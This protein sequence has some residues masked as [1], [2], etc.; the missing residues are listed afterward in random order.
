MVGGARV[1]VVRVRVSGCRGLLTASCLACR[2]AGVGVK[3][4]R[5]RACQG[6]VFEVQGL[7]TALCLACHD[8]RVG[9]RASGM[10]GTSYKAGPSS[11]RRLP[12]CHSHSAVGLAQ[13]TRRPPSRTPPRVW[14]LDCQL[15]KPAG[16]FSRIFEEGR[17][18]RAVQT[19]SQ[20]KNKARATQ[21][22]HFTHTSASLKADCQASSGWYTSV[23]SRWDRSSLACGGR[24]RAT[25]LSHIGAGWCGVGFKHAGMQTNPECG[26]RVR[27]GA[28][29]H[30]QSHQ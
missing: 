15:S 4:I 21:R 6:R 23:C 25:F 13:T 7:L 16:P 1:R 8:G 24:A 3:V 19:P 27:L 11:A 20:T 29:R 28:A 30:E 26:G 10:L 12:A 18:A 17:L 9:G 2:G 22:R 14:N 5:V